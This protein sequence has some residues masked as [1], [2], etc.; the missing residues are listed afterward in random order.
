MLVLQPRMSTT[1]DSSGAGVGVS[2]AVTD[3]AGVTVCDGVAVSEGV[4]VSGVVTAESGVGDSVVMVGKTGGSR[5]NGVAVTTPGV[6]VGMGVH[7]GNGCGGAPHV[8]QAEIKIA[9]T[10]KGNTTFFIRLLYLP[11]RSQSFKGSS[12]MTLCASLA[13]PPG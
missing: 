6:R 2:D 7:T 13:R 9:H 12:Q 1:M 4:T 3:G 5:I 11:E 10:S 8:S